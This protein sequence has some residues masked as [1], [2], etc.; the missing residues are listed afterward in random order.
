MEDKVILLRWRFRLWWRWTSNRVQWWW[1]W[2]RLGWEYRYKGFWIEAD[3]VEIQ[4]TSEMVYWARRAAAGEDVAACE[5][6][7]EP[8]EQ[9]EA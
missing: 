5:E 4:T 6:P 3:P 7:E 1:V 9:E 2:I 8:E